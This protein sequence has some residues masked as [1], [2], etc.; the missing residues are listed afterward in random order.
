MNNTHTGTAAQDDLR[1]KI[2][3]AITAAIQDGAI[4]ATGTEHDWSI[5]FAIDGER[6]FY[7]NLI[8][9]CTAGE[10]LDLLNDWILGSGDTSRAAEVCE[11]LMG[12]NNILRLIA[13]D[14][15]SE[16]INHRNYFDH[17]SDELIAQEL[18]I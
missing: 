11:Y 10:K 1:G 14:V 16:I 18:P 9:I 12:Q 5:G 13:R 6:C 8:S 2:R 3:L 7:D 17:A 15:A 4:V